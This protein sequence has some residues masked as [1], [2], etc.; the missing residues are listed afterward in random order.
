MHTQDMV[1]ACHA[2]KTYAIIGIAANCQIKVKVPE[3]LLEGDGGV[4]CLCKLF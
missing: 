4:N 1:C 3:F 2:L